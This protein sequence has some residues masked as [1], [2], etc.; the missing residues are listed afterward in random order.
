MTYSLLDLE[1][2]V[3]L[4]GMFSQQFVM[5]LAAYAL[6]DF[7]FFLSIDEVRKRKRRIP[8]CAL[9][10]PCYSS[11]KVLLASRNEQA[12]ITFTGLDVAA[13]EYLLVRF[14]VLYSRYSPYVVDGKIV[15]LRHERGTKGGRPRTFD[16]AGCL[17][18]ILSYTRTRGSVIGLQ[19][20]FGASHSVLVL[21]LKYSMR[22]L[23]KI[24]LEEDA[25]K[26]CI[27]S[28]D[29]IREYQSII[30][31]NFPALDG[32]WCVM[33]G[34]KL[35]VQSSGV[36]VEQNAYYNGWLHDH[37]VS[38]VYVFA[39]SGHIVAQSLN[40]PG[41]WHDSLVA[42]N[43][44]IYNELES[45]YEACG[46]KCVVDSAF[47]QKRCPYLI[48]SGNAKP[49]ETAERRRIRCQ[50]TVMRQASEWGMRAIQGSFPRLKDRFLFSDDR[51]DR[52]IFLHLVSML[53]NFRTTFVGM[54]QLESTFY[55]LF[56][57][58]GDN[59]LEIYQ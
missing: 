10:N 44:N 54:N 8:R 21:F 47:N 34:L 59:V 6:V 49:G 39:P 52:R 20:M 27:P 7:T 41:S 14:E 18:L 50:A 58:V 26:V 55:P 56:E 43:G 40:N 31:L 24:L 11:V 33:D 37:F 4:L 29:K 25:A 16:A 15:P 2:D 46:G 3:L 30:R 17:A 42:L 57:E 32:A 1:E 53:L 5:M 51:Q 23:Y 22:L 36:D 28:A 9:S 12:Y 35:L 38:C 48:K 13:F 19:V 45:V